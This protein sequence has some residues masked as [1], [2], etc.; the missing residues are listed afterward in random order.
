MISSK[1]PYA[2]SCKKNTVNRFTVSTLL[3][4]DRV[5]LKAKKA[6]STQ[7]STWGV[8]EK[9]ALHT[10]NLVNYNFALLI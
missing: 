1:Q 5:V 6:K 7:I 2:H 10:S 4:R 9:N 8:Y 3:T